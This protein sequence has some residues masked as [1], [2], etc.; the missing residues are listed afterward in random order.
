[1]MWADFISFLLIGLGAALCVQGIL[2]LRRRLTLRAN[3]LERSFV[4]LWE[5]KD[6]TRAPQILG[7]MRIIYGVFFIILGF[8]SLL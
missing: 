7:R 1:M 3:F 5:T 8:W 4:A 6:K 2:A